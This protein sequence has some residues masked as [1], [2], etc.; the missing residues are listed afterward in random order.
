MRKTICLLI[1]LIVASTASADWIEGDQHKMHY[2]QLPDPFGW[3]I[4]F[5]DAFLG[6][7]FMCTETGQ[8]TDIH[9]WVSWAFDN[10]LDFDIQ[11]IGIGIWSDLRVGV[12]FSQP[13]QQLWYRD[14]FPGE[15]IITDPFLGEQG[16]FDPYSGFYHPFDNHQLYFQINIDNIPDPFWQT[17]DTIYWLVIYIPF[18]PEPDIGIGW[19]T[20]LE[21]WE[22]DAVYGIPGE[23]YE[24]ISPTTGES[25]DLA[26]VITN[27]DQVPVQLSSFTAAYSNGT[28]TLFWT[29]QSE[30]NN[31]GW[32]VFRS[33]NDNLEESMQINFDLIPGAGTTSEPTDYVFE[34]DHEV[35]ANEEYWYWL[36]SVENSGET[37]TYGP[38]SLVIPED[39]DEP[40][41]PEIPDIYGLHQNYP[42][43]FNPLADVRSAITR[44]SY[45]M[46]T[47]CTGTLKI[48]NLKGE[49]IVTLF[50]DL[51]LRADEKGYVEWNGKDESA[52]L[53]PSGVY[54]YELNTDNRNY[55]RKLIIIR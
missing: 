11:F 51:E 54:I 30:S 20:S 31:I 22:D 6:D 49:E 9:F 35:V 27:D 48:Y 38:I 13:D 41:I 44:I 43:P 36:E 3:D 45:M 7:D 47:D 16:W 23:W 10:V 46:D 5:G 1:L 25:L 29:T 8:I 28:S 37:E 14:F 42:N 33:E 2:P 19:K 53:I 32:N 12:P 15:F 50:A 26:F 17:Q 52:K 24:L 18:W 39:G 40:D 55:T 21:H 34:D 4:N